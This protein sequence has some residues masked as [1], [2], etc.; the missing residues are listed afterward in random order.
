MR[1]LPAGLSV[2]AGKLLLAQAAFAE[3]S[4]PEVFRQLDECQWDLRGW[5]KRH[6]RWRFDS[7]KQTL[8]GHTDGVSSVCFSPD[9]KRILTGRGDSTAKVWDT[10]KGAEVLV[11]KGHTSGV[12]SV[13]FSADGKRLFAWDATGKVLAWSVVD[14]KLAPPTIPR[15][16]PLPVRPIHSTAG[17]PPNPKATPSPSS[18]CSSPRPFKQPPG[19]CPMPPS[20]RPTTRSRRTSQIRRGNGSPSPSTS[21]ACCSMIPTT[22]T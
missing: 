13:C 21:V 7:S 14:G 3:N 8:K 5:E 10:D 11:L 17:S 1:F 12:K 2:Y 22:P 19:R 6:L 9:G 4:M 16:G 20:G 18:I 15:P